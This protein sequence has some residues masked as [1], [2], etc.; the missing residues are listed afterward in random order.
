MLMRSGIALKQ[1]LAL[2]TLF[3]AKKLELLNEDIE[4]ALK[5]SFPDYYGYSQERLKEIGLWFLIE[6]AA[7]RIAAIRWL[8][9][10]AVL[11]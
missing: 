4:A 8:T 11:V 6:K 9:E 7:K 2:E 5:D 3:E 1:G 10:T